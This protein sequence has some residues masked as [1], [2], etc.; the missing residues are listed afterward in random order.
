MP[1]L[2]AEVLV[3][4]NPLLNIQML[5]RGYY[6]VRCSFLD[7]DQ[8]LKFVEV[9]NVSNT[10]I[11]PAYPEAHVVD[12]EGI[13]QTIFIEY[14]QQHFNLDNFFVF[15]FC[16]PLDKGYQT[17]L[18]TKLCMRL[19]LFHNEIDDCPTDISNFKFVCIR[20][21]TLNIDWSKDYY[22]FVNVCF[23][24]VNFAA[25]G[26][27]VNASLTGIDTED[28][29]LPRPNASK[30]WVFSS[31]EPVTLTMSSFLFGGKGNSVSSGRAS[32][33]Q[34]SVEDL[35]QARKL[36]DSVC[37]LLL[38]A[39]DQVDSS[40]ADEARALCI[41]DHS[42][43]DD[44]MGLSTDD[45][46]ICCKEKLL[47]LGATLSK[48]WSIN[49][50]LK[51]FNPSHC[52]HLMTSSHRRQ[53]LFMLSSIVTH[54][55]QL[56]G[57][58]DYNRE[59]A[60]LRSNLTYPWPIQCVETQESGR[61]TTI[62]FEEFHRWDEMQPVYTQ[63]SFLD[64]STPYLLP[65]LHDDRVKPSDA[66]VHLIV[67]VHGLQGTPYDLQLYKAYLELA[68]PNVCFNFLLSMANEEDTFTDF[69]TMTDRLLQEFLSYMES[70]FSPTSHVSFIGSSLGNI[71]IRCL[72][73]RPEMTPYLS[74]LHTFISIC[75]PHLGTLHAGSLVGTGMWVMRKWFK[76]QSLLQLSLRDGSSP[77]DSFLYHLSLCPGFEYFKNVLLLGSHQDKYVPFHSARLQPYSGHDLI[78]SEMIQSLLQPMQQAKVNLIR[79]NID[80]PLALNSNSLIGR[81]AHI[82]MLDS[83]AFVEKFVIILCAKYFV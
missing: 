24:F 75:G 40:A 54:L 66:A 49:C 72:L 28:T 2:T 50:A 71:V 57:T 36:C 67:C 26:V 19:R 63:E 53:V 64:H 33:Y 46:L 39:I 83:M 62:I 10:S 79:Y 27:F 31:Q 48:H 32:A 68:F 61:T 60:T 52:K 74:R 29:I 73:T 20:N 16:L 44:L 78:S 55:P 13:S 17:R 22:E 69:N 18:Q 76:S 25:L 81:A 65:A 59:A 51:A 3:H 43:P 4:L 82:A 6:H 42:L 37:E 45:M 9:R 77:R 70:C 11:I 1:E 23:D 41:K 21:V 80:H 35:S 38:S 58:R 14:E 5:R 30:K 12:K 56:Q 8:L 34:V 15:T 7:K 47:F